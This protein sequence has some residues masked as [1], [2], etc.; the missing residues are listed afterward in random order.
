VI[1][2]NLLIFIATILKRFVVYFARPDALAGSLLDTLLYVKPQVFFAV[3][4]IYEKFEE[5][6]RLGIK[7]ASFIKKKIVRFSRN[8]GTKYVD[9]I[10]YG[11]GGTPLMYP[12]ANFLMFRKIKKAMGLDECEMFVYGAAP[13]KRKT[14]DF[15]KS[16]GMIL[17]NNYGLS[18]TSGP[19]F[20]NNFSDIATVGK[21]LPGTQGKIMNKD[22]DGV[23]EICFRGRP[24]FMGYWKNEEATK[25]AIDDKGY[26]HTGDQGYFNKEGNLII[27]GRIKELIVTAGGEN[28]A[29]VPIEDSFK[30]VCKIV[31]NIIIIGDY[32]KYLSAF[33]TLKTDPEGRFQKEILDELKQLGSEAINIIEAI[34]DNK[35]KAYIEKCLE[36]VNKKSVSRAQ[37]IKKYKILTHDFSIDT[38]EFTPT[39]KLK[40]KFVTQKYSKEI[41]QM[42]QDP[43]F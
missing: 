16:L 40:R 34:N 5:R 43:K 20:T 21:S 1:F 38:G 30:E 22:T 29:P 17:F 8:Q 23:G 6:I 7:D 14:F 3:P 2:I 31:S 26:L 18:E 15:F 12:V 24:R 11:K 10:S 36:L 32:R 41:E 35:V 42:Y 4:R 39:M 25:E 37:V 9:N 33:I 13:L 28:V 27:S 19:A